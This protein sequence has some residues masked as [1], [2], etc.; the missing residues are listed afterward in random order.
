MLCNLETINHA[1]YAEYYE[2]YAEELA[3]VERHAYLKVALYLLE[4]LHKE[5]EGKDIGKAIAKE[6]SCTHLARHMLVKIPTD[7]A[8]YGIRNSF[9]K[10]CRMARK[11]VDLCEDEA[12]ITSCG[13]S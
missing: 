3:H 4:E 2:G 9:I 11:H 5:T 8:K 13:A 10:L 12:K 1:P 6:K 7:Q